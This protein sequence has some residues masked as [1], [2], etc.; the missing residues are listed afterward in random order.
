MAFTYKMLAQGQS[1]SA[2]V[3]SFNTIF[4]VGA[5]KSVIIN[6]FDIHNTGASNYDVAIRI[7]PSGATAGATH[8]Y[9]TPGTGSTYGRV[10]STKTL[11]VAGPITLSAGDSIQLATS[12]ASVIN[13]FIFGVEIS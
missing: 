10:D 6:K 12:T 1:S 11:F 2:S 4:T 13:Y 3:T 7:V 5:G 9:G 8:Q